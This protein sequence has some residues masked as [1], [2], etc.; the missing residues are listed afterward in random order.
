MRGSKRQGRL[1][2]RASSTDF[3]TC[4]VSTPGPTKDVVE[5]DKM[6]SA[7][8]HAHC[9]QLLVGRAQD[10]DSRLGDVDSKLTDAME[11]IEGLEEA[12][13]IKLD[14]KFQEV[15]ARSYIVMVSATISAT[16][17]W[18]YTSTYYLQVHRACITSTIG[19][20]STTTWSSSS[21]SSMASM[22]KTR[23]IQCRKCLGFGHIERECRTKR[24]MLVREDGE[25]DSASDF[26]EDTLA[27]IAA[28]DGANSDFERERGGNGSSLLIS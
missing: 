16:I 10:V 15:L 11:K 18:G 17:S 3:S 27:L 2:G 24:V 9:T 4:F 8:L 19:C 22:G 1:A 26:D 23:D 20:Y 14:A 13:N 5:P 12:F 25:Y 6:T 28:R 21:S 7:E